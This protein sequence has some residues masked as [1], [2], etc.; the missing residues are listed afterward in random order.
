MKLYRTKNDN[1]INL[2]GVELIYKDPETGCYFV[3]T[4]SGKTYEMPE[5]EKSDIVK[6]MEYNNF[7]IN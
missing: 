7:L 3:A 5:I 4:T 1:I 2:E 6:I